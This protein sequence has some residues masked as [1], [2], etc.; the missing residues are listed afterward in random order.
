MDYNPI[1]LSFEPLCNHLIVKKNP[2]KCEKEKKN[3]FSKGKEK[4]LAMVLDLQKQTHGKV[5]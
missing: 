4:H 5:R 1:K 3:S 2:K